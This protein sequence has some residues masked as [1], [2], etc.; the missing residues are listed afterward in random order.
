M[1]F[2]ISPIDGQKTTQNGIIYAYSTSTNSWRR[3]FN[4]VLDHLTIG[5]IENAVNTASGALVVFGGTSVG[6]DL[7]V[8]GIIYQNGVPISSASTYVWVTVNSDYVVVSGIHLFVDTSIA[9]F[10]ITL[11]AVPNVG[12][13]VTFIDYAGTCGTNILTFD[14]NGNLIMGLAENL[15]IDVANAANS[16]IYSGPDFGWKIGAVF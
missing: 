2:P 7:W 16:L 10:T 8:G 9:P 12:D 3:D 1:S 5:G 14:R 15:D 11:P 6:R 13:N 4:N